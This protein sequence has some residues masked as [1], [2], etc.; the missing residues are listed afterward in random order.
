MLVEALPMAGN[1]AGR[2]ATRSP[3]A[4]RSRLWSKTAI[5]RRRFSEKARQ[6]VARAVDEAHGVGFLRE[7]EL[8]FRDGGIKHGGHR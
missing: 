2:A 3:V 8:P 6:A 4:E 1:P 5:G 7:K